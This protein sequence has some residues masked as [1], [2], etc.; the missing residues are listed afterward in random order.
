MG[1]SDP[2]E[3]HARRWTGR[4]GLGAG[5]GAGLGL[6]AG[7]VWGSIAY[8][9]GSFGMWLVA[10]GCVLFLGILG[11]FVGGLSGLESTD[12]GRE[13]FQNEEPLAEPDDLI[14]PERGTGAPPRSR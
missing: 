1:L 10:V 8:R 11:A 4:I 2:Q 3:R 5:I 6:V 9:A 14:G 12:P 7:L 13:P